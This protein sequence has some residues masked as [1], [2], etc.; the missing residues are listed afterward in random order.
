MA[1]AASPQCKPNQS[2]QAVADD[3]GACACVE[4]REEYVSKDQRHKQRP[5][6]RLNPTHLPSSSFSSLVCSHYCRFGS[7]CDPTVLPS[8]GM[9]LKSAKFLS[10]HVMWNQ[11][12]S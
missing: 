3:S 5:G 10:V 1:V 8:P 11:G 7:R 6:D 4:N 9:N 12:E 2:C